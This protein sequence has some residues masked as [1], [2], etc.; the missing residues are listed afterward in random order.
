MQPGSSL[1][2]AS[3]QLELGTYGRW[4]ATGHRVPSI[5]SDCWALHTSPTQLISKPIYCFRGCKAA[6]GVSIM[7]VTPDL[8]KISPPPLTTLSSRSSQCIMHYLSQIP[9]PPPSL[10]ES[11]VLNGRPLENGAVGKVQSTAGCCLKQLQLNRQSVGGVNTSS[12]RCLEML[13]QQ[14]KVVGY[15]NSMGC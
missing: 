4:N 3:L 15:Q 8:W 9:P 5:E 14:L 1:L 12:D 13:I 7:Y 6:W 10:L 11:D 2:I